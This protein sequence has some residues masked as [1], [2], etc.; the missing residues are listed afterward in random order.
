MSGRG[1]A[2]VAVEPTTALITGDEVVCTA[3]SGG[4]QLPSGQSVSV[5]VKMTQGQTGVIRIGG[6][7]DQSPYSGKGLVLGPGD[8]YTVNVRNP[9]MIRAH[10]SVSGEKLSWIANQ[11][12]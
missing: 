11:Y 10:A 3:L 8:S 5:T 7:G 6:V 1:I 2:A 12:A 9:N 4:T